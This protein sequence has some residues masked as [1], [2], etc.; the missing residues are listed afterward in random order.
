LKRLST[1][2]KVEEGGIEQGRD[3]PKSKKKKEVTSKGEGGV[4]KN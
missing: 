1:S 4:N 3:A 2:I